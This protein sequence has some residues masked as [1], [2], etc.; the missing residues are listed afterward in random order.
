VPIAEEKH[1]KR[2]KIS[3]KWALENLKK[4]KSSMMFPSTVSFFKKNMMENYLLL[5][6]LF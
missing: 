2:V 1:L 5:I 3:K 4:R 6:D